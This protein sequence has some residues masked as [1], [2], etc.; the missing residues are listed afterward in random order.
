MIKERTVSLRSYFL[1]YIV[2]NYLVRY[3]WLIHVKIY[4]ELLIITLINR[5][6]CHAH[7]FLITKKNWFPQNIPQKNARRLL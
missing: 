2:Q 1:K 6:P 4:C 5:I 7:G 3:A